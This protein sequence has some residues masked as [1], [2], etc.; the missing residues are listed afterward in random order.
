[1]SSASLSLTDSIGADRRCSAHSILLH[2]PLAGYQE[3][4]R[5]LLLLRA[6]AADAAECAAASRHVCDSRGMLLAVGHLQSARMAVACDL[7]QQPG[8]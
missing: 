1:M 7:V 2:S 6:P 8:R 4:S 5:G 3:T